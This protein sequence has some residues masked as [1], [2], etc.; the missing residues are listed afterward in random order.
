MKK[1]LIALQILSLVFVFACKRPGHVTTAL[2]APGH[3][4]VTIAISDDGSG[5]YIVE[6]SVPNKAY[7]KKGQK[8]HWIVINNTEAATVS[9][10]LIDSF[11]DQAGHTDPFEGTPANQKFTFPAIGP[12]AESKQTSNKAKTFPPGDPRQFKYKVTVTI[13]GVAKPISVDPVVIVGD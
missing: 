5:G 1:V 11:L 12:G 10:T 9:T 7:L 13:A 4:T 3:K 6:A 2:K 8:V